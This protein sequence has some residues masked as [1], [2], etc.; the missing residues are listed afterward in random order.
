MDLTGGAFL[1]L[2][3]GLAIAAAALTVVCWPRLSA[4]RPLPVLG[5]VGAL[6]GLNLLVL[7]TVGLVA[8]D[9]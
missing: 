2:V 8:N 5:R 7:A 4:Q 3:A 9:V 1:T 6:L